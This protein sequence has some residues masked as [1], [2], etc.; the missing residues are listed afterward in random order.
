VVRVEE[1][2]SSAPGKPKKSFENGALRP[3]NRQD[4]PW[5]GPGCSR[6]QSNCQHSVASVSLT[7]HKRPHART[8][9]QRKP[10][11]RVHSDQSASPRRECQ[12][13]HDANQGGCTSLGRTANAN[14]TT[15]LLFAARRARRLHFILERDVV[16]LQQV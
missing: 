9:L 14:G 12:Q 3:G 8:S 5:L 13:G 15:G 11:P 6:E 1:C 16:D 2:A 10:N 4:P 7:A